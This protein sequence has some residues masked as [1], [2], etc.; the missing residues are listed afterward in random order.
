MKLDDVADRRVF[1][2][3]ISGSVDVNGEVLNAGD[4]VQVGGETSIDITSNDDAEL[5][6][7]NMS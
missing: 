1:V 7:F 6:L 4:G 2:Q 3:V 5:L